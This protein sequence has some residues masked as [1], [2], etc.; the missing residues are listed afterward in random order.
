MAQSSGRIGDIAV[1]NTA[2]PLRS[3]A[4][5]GILDIAVLMIR[6]SAILLLLSPILL[7]TMLVFA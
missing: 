2:I 1:A 5:L 6:V 4:A 7:L 3:V